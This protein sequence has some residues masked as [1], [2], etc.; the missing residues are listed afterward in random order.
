MHGVRRGRLNLASQLERWAKFWRE[1]NTPEDVEWQ[2]R[3]LLWLESFAF[4]SGNAIS[5]EQYCA[6]QQQ[7]E[8]GQKK[9]AELRGELGME[10]A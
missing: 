5:I 3:N 1:V 6:L 7:I 2:L 10:A 8:I 9:L 4:Q